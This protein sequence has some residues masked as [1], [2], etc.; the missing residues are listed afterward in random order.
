MGDD[1]EGNWVVE[2][3]NKDGEEHSRRSN[4]IELKN[5]RGKWPIQGS[6]GW[7]KDL[8]SWN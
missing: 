6:C 5:Q 8:E 2:E 4:A 1:E 7:D 3:G